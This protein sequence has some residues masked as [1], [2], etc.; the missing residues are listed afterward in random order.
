V[1]LHFD[2]LHKH[3]IKDKVAWGPIK[4]G[5]VAGSLIAMDFKKR[6]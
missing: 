3:A 4:E 2:S 1:K 6:F 5:I